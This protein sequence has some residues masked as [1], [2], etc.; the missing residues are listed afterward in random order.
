M[1]SDDVVTKSSNDIVATSSDNSIATL[2]KDITTAHASTAV[3]SIKRKQASP[4]A[5][6]ESQGSLEKKARTL[7][8]FEYIHD[9][10]GYTFKNLDLLNEAFDTTG[11]HR[12]QSNQSLALIGDSVL[13]LTIYRDWYPSRQLK[14][15]SAINMNIHVGFVADPPI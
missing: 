4:D 5:Q 13:Q 3:T 8:A 10:F 14:G 9:T 12:P 6:D 2:S 15:M 11:V 1:S 7:N